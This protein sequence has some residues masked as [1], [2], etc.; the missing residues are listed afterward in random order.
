MVKH[1]P[2]TPRIFV[3]SAVVLAM[4]VPV[5]ARPL[6]NGIAANDRRW[7]SPPHNR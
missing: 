6:E 3:I 5:L 1:R 7:I 4:A 2:G